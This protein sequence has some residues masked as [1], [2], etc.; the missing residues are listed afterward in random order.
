VKQECPQSMTWTP[1]LRSEVA[2]NKQEC[3]GLIQPHGDPFAWPSSTFF[4]VEMGLVTW[5]SRILTCS[6]MSDGRSVG[7]R[8]AVLC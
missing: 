3:S 2:S 7:F 1:P 4:T 6:E 8:E 5:A